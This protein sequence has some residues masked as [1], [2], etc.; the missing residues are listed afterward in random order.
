MDNTQVTVSNETI[1]KRLFSC[2]I[3]GTS[4]KD[5]GIVSCIGCKPGKR[6]HK[7]QDGFIIYTPSH[8]VYKN[9]STGRAVKDTNDNDFTNK[10][11][12]RL[13]AI[14]DG[15]GNAGENMSTKA[16]DLVLEKICSKKP[17][18]SQN[19]HAC[20]SEIFHEIHKCLEEDNESDIS[21]T[22]CTV[23]SLTGNKLQVSSVFERL[24]I[25]PNYHISIFEHTSL[26]SQCG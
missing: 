24:D 19:A 18:L 22:T 9:N 21:G 1:F 16:R 2:L 20:F 23:I 6:M 7:N 17:W 12:A 4:S 26:G 25:L 3:S 14:L 13:Y 10:L 11:N 5:F 15:H 8:G